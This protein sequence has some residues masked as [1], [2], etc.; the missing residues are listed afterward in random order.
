MSLEFENVNLCF[1]YGMQYQPS[2]HLGS[3]LIERAT[4]GYSD[5][6]RKVITMVGVGTWQGTSMFRP[7]ELPTSWIQG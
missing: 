7:M 6:I 2:L 5:L 3:G 4:S 1:Q